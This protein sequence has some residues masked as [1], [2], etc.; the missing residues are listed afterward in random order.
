MGSNCHVTRIDHESNTYVYA[1]MHAYIHTY[2]HTNMHMYI[3][4][5]MHTYSH[6][7]ICRNKDTYNVRCGRY[8]TEL[9]NF[10]LHTCVMYDG[11]VVKP[12]ELTDVVC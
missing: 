9:T 6:T 3:Q 4:I 1:C 8:I 12:V 11:A 10:R 2:I 5:C 7:C